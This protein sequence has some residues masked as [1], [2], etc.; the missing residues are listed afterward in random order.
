VCLV[1]T[2]ADQAASSVVL[3]HDVQRG[4]S[5]GLPQQGKPKNKWSINKGG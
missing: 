3:E 5:A 4:D 1:F 2:G